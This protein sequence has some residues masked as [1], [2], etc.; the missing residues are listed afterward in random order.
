MDERRPRRLKAGDTQTSV[1]AWTCWV[2]MLMYEPSRR[3]VC[4]GVERMISCSVLWP[5][6]AAEWPG[7]CP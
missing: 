7:R 1:C 3:S 4:R 2:A 5:G 6:A